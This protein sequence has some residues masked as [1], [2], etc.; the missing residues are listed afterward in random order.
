MSFLSSSL[1]LLFY[2]HLFYPPG[3]MTPTELGKGESRA[4]RKSEIFYLNGTIVSCF[5]AFCVPKIFKTD[6]FL[7]CCQRLIV[8]L[9]KYNSYDLGKQVH[10]FGDGGFSLN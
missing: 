8:S 9:S 6:S 4:K 7:C 3:K 5:H 10:H 2:P 1:S